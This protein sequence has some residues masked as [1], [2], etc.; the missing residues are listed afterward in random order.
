MKIKIL[1]LSFVLL[2]VA[3][4]TQA[5]DIPRKYDIS[6]EKVLY[7]VGYSHLD[8]QW[9]W[10]YP[11]TIDVCLKNLM[12]QNFVLFETYPDYVFNF[13]GS[14][15]Y[16][17]MKEY[18]PE[19]YPK[20]KDY[21]RRG[22]WFVSGSSVDEGE[23][24]ISSSESVIRQVLYGNN[25]F[26]SEFGKESVDFMLPDCFGFLSTLPSL[27]NHCGLLGFSTQKLTWN[28]AVGIPF[29]VG[30]WNGPDGKG[31]IAALN[32]TGYGGRVVKR[33][34]S[35]STWNAR[36]DENNDKH[37]LLFDYRYYG[38]GDQG[39]SPRENDVRNAVGSL[40]HPD[41]KFKVVLTSSDQM[42]KDITSQI[43]GKMPVYSGDLLLTEH[44]AGTQTSQ[45]FMKR[46]NRKN[47]HLA[48]SAEQMAVVAEIF[49]GASYPLQKLN[50]SWELL[51][52][53]Q[54]HDILPGTSIPKAY[55]YSW[56]DEFVAAN[57]FS[58]VLVNSLR[59]I[60][61]GLDTRTGGRTIV[62]YNPVAIEREDVAN[63]EL[64]YKTL[65]ENIRVLNAQGE[66]VPSQIIGR[67]G[68][69]LKFIF[70]AH[71]SSV[72]LAVF[73]V[74]ETSKSGQ[75]NSALKITSNT[76]E[77]AYYKVSVAENGDIEAIFDKKLKKNILSKPVRLEF[78]SEKPALYP[79]WNMDWNDRKNP[80][81]G[82]LDKDATI[83]II[84]N[85]NVRVSLLITRKGKNTEIEQILSLSAGDAGKRVEV[86][87]KIDWQSTGVSLK[88][89]FAFA[90]ENQSASYNLGVASIRRGNNDEKK[91]E[92]PSTQWIDL[93][94]KSGKFGVSVLEDC[95][96]GSDKPDDHTLRL[97][98]LYTPE[99]KGDRFRYQNSQ[100][101][102]IHDVKYALYSHSANWNQSETFWQSE[103]VNKPLVTF[104]T[105]KHEGELNKEYSF[106]KLNSSKVRLMAYKKAEQVDYYIVRVNELCGKDQK[107]VA[108][109]FSSEIEDAYEVN[110]QEQKTGK[111]TFNKETLSFDIS[112]F[113]IRSFAVKFRKK[114]TLPEQLPV[115]LPYNVDVMTFDRNRA[116]CENARGLSYPAELIPSELISEDIRF[117]MG[118]TQDESFNAVACKGQTIV[119]PSSEYNKIYLLAAAT[120][121]TKGVFM[122]NDKR[123]EL[124]VG[125]WTGFV[126]QY[127]NRRFDVDGETVLDIK[128]PF[129]NKDNIVWFASHRHKGYPTA[130]ESYQYTYIYK[131][132]LD[133]PANTNSIKLPNNSKIRIFA[134]TLARQM[135]D[136]LQ[137]SAPLY[138]DFS[139][140]KK[141]TLRKQ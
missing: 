22:R 46:M 56:N 114:S 50:K 103:F 27:L 66:E 9:N 82:F 99:V 35:D 91:Y 20:V 100:D 88:A 70:L 32:A 21:I 102:G 63:A 61:S 11:V 13:T 58:Q 65:P 104:E 126:G 38:I 123:E 42:Y 138:D 16:Q 15:R 28:S 54:M 52:G 44:S 30:I 97:T 113:A 115:K 14:R 136:N 25:F 127:Y 62:V 140:N 130:N 57:G 92:V 60:S 41:S 90:A 131:Y 132:E 36:I 75:K 109:K 125:T 84:E 80:P 33:L 51:L 19:Y 18:Y 76:L 73:D 71:V 67:E 119:L 135:G 29:N 87:N 31:I 124:A 2:Q 1:L 37:K 105:Q 72:G 139:G 34:D 120:V 86:M 48:S 94:D 49:T 83:R 8:T 110:G 45:A 26:R 106:L 137:F 3:M 5:L 74:Q 134:I 117:V 69:K 111:V 78:L 95:K 7:T 141:I 23:V 98:L 40:N 79:A 10:D 6:K 4:I 43:M 59:R 81:V 133:L 55:E 64:Y 68:N 17:M 107:S 129:V 39:G 89:S 108:V 12:T 121:D 116:D 53:S 101:W 112:H 47:E 122:L 93:T 24:N 118:D 85:G 77:N 96:Y 128:E